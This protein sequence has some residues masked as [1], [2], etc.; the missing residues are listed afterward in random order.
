MPIINEPRVR[1]SAREAEAAEDIALQA[2]AAEREGDWD[3]AAALYARTFRSALFEGFAE[4][5]AD[6]LRG[7]ARVRQQQGR[8]EEAEELA[9]L[10]RELADRHGLQQAAA[11]AHNILG[12]I[13]Y[14][15]QDW[16]G[17]EDQY[18]RALELALDTGDDE[19]I[20]LACQNLG[21]M[22]NLRGDLREA[23][24]RYLES[25]GSFV[26][27]GTSANAIMAYN[28]LGIAATELREWMEAEVYFSR[29]IE[30]AERL[31]HTQ[32]A[33]MLYSNRAEPLIRI[34]ETARARESLDV[35][36]EAAT[37][38]RD[39]AT[40]ADVARF[41]GMLAREEGDFASAERYLVESLE[42][43]GSPDLDL[44]KAK[45]LRELGEL[46]QALGRNTEAAEAYGRAL[47]YFRAFGAEGH[48]AEVDREMGVLAGVGADAS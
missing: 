36:E 13:R 38:A 42:L 5:A 32:L 15:L 14:S 19:L 25:V 16:G 35:A 9:Y 45:A 31:A 46:H 17:A 27:S 41:R 34:G 1:A 39:Q 33:G 6:A 48:A 23:R 28:N 40:L 20:G 47:S 44:E 30:I 10:S 12:I 18:R 21:V 29:G 43:S 24:S 4:R 7:Q 37:R 2:A 11:R 26:R 3:T 8:Y 22:A